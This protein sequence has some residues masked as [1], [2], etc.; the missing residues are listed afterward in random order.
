MTK[1][2]KL[3]AW[4]VNAKVFVRLE[5][6]I[7]NGSALVAEGDSLVAAMSALVD[8]LLFEDA[9]ANVYDL[10]WNDEKIIGASK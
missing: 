3:Q 1:N 6:D 7:P 9:A 8:R 5:H 2:I 10:I 4:E